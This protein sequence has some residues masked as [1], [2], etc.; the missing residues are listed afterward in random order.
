RLLLAG[1]ALELA[2]FEAL[3]RRLGSE[4]AE[5][6]ET[7]LAG[8]LGRWS[9]VLVAEGAVTA[10]LGRRHRI[11]AAAGGLAA[12]AGCA[13]GRFAVVEAGRAAARDPRYVV[14]PQRR[15]LAES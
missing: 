4:L 14:G 15:A 9:G 6:Y 11:V 3:H 5:T 1:A 12:A 10:V 7:G 2:A 8:K 13:L